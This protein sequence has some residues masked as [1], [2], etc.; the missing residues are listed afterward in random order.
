M[1][2]PFV[3]EDVKQLLT[4]LAAVEGP[5]MHEVDPA[6]ARAMYQQ[7]GSIA[8]RPAP[9]DVIQTDLSI[10][11]PAGAI[12]ARS[13]RPADP[14]A[15]GTAIVF[16]HGGG[17]VIGDLQTHNSLAAEIAKL[18]GFPTVAIDYR[19]APEAPWPAAVDDALAAARWIAGS[20]AELGFPVSRLIFAG[21]SAG[22]N[23]SAIAARALR[24]ETPVAAQWLIYPGVDMAAAEGSMVEFA[25][26]YL[27]TAASMLWFGNHYAA[28]AT[29]PNASPIL[30]DDWA[31]LPPAL[32]F[33]CGL[34]PLRDQG[35]AYAG[36]LIAAGNR[37]VFREAAG[38]VHGSAQLRQAIPSAQTDL[39]AQVADLKALLA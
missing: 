2:M 22:G 25:E 28:D 16:F 3:R 18:T 38:Q 4:M 19:L 32:V 34:D 37:V 36:K 12:R 21:D 1:D 39:E 15:D 23:L 24:R 17:W 11:G 26:G 10:P 9:A 30:S 6:T 8:E 14:V 31:E 20:P 27:L 35:R 13:Y 7:M 29:H 5:Q 33:T